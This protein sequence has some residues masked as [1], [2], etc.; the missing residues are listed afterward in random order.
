MN[1]QKAGWGG[2][3]THAAFALLT[4][5][6][7]IIFT[8]FSCGNLAYYRVACDPNQWF[9]QQEKVEGNCTIMA[10]VGEN[11]YMAIKKIN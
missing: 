9:R 6:D 5:R 4:Q 11:H 10:Y 7:L 2:Q 8:H 3:D 1:S